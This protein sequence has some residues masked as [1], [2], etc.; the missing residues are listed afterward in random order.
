MRGR[1]GERERRGERERERGPDSP[2]KSDGE[3]GRVRDRDR[4]RLRWWGQ[5][6]KGPEIGRDS[7]VKNRRDNDGRW[8]TETKRAT[9][10]DVEKTNE[11]KQVAEMREAGECVGGEGRWSQSRGPRSRG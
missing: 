5:T 11:T 9:G 4:R 3:A 7:P 8:E 6:Q 2:G 10:R 1:E